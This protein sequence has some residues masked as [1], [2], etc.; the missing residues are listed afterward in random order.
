MRAGCSVVA[1]NLSSIPEVAGSAGILVYR[2][3]VNQ[4]SDALGSVD[5]NRTKIIQAGIEQ[6]SKFSWDN[7]FQKTVDL[8]KK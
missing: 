2:A 1:V 3:E 8:Y 4:L 7:C 5:H 6:A